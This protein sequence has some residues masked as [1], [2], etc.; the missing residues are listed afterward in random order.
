ML[1]KTCWGIG[2]TAFFLLAMPLQA[3]GAAYSYV[4][5]TS[6]DIPGGTAKGTITLPDL[7]T[8]TVTFEAINPNGSAGNLFSA[9]VTDANTVDY[10][11]PKEP[12]RTTSIR[13]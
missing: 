8:V 11:M 9:Q 12:Q 1:N 10:W 4:D 2:L 7:S 6:T 5:W 13:R 3:R